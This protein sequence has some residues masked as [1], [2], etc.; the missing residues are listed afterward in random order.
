MEDEHGRPGGLKNIPLEFRELQ[1]GVLT[2]LVSQCEPHVRDAFAMECICYS[3][4]RLCELRDG[5]LK[6]EDDPASKR[7]R[8]PTSLNPGLEL[9]EAGYPQVC[10]RVQTRTVCIISTG[11]LQLDCVASE[12]APAD[13][14]HQRV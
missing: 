12:P 2:F 5:N 1:P 14:K 7:R 11:R 6:V 10:P 13:M 9:L 8:L 4:G 3:I